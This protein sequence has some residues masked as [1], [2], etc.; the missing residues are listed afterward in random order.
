MTL[1]QKV[2]ALIGDLILRNMGL[3]AQIEALQAELDK[4]K[5]NG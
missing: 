1:D 2:R 3:E 4:L 5:A